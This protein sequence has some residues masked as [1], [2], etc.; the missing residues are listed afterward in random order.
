MSFSSLYTINILYYIDW[1]LECKINFALLKWT[2]L[3]SWGYL[4]TEKWR[5]WKRALIGR[6]CIMI[7]VDKW[8]KWDKDRAVSE[9]DKIWDISQRLKELVVTGVEEFVIFR[10][11]WYIDHTLGYK[12]YKKMMVIMG[13]REWYRSRTEHI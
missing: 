6:E 4:Q 8:Y 13:Q 10:P 3:G 7:S 5:N 2:P 9:D 11:R 12:Y 1:F